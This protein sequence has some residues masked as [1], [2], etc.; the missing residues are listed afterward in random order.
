MY[1]TQLRAD[2]PETTMKSAISGSRLESPKAKLIS[3]SKQLCSSRAIL[4]TLSGSFA[5]MLPSPCRYVL[6]ARFE[7]FE[8]NGSNRFRH[9]VFCLFVDFSFLRLRI[10]PRALDSVVLLFGRQ[11]GAVHCNLDEQSIDWD[12]HVRDFSLFIISNEEH[13]ISL[14][15]TTKS[16]ETF[17]SAVIEQDGNVL[18]VARLWPDILVV[19]E[20]VLEAFEEECSPFGD[21]YRCIKI[22]GDAIPPAHDSRVKGRHFTLLR[23]L[24]EAI[25][26]EEI[27]FVVL[28]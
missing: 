3:A 6:G 8:F 23:V 4:I 7:S 13:M 14:I 17:N 11:T 5:Y 12:C 18:W 9:R 1:N 15:E 26:G 22:L 2:L 24:P 10:S 19:E 21:G 25:A 28:R 27:S 16:D 20:P